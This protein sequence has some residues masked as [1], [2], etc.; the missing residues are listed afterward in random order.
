MLFYLVPK[1]YSYLPEERA[2][3][4]V[5]EYLSNYGGQ[6][7]EVVVSSLLCSLGQCSSL[8]PVDWTG[9]LLNIT[10]GMPNMCKPCLQCAIKLTETS[11]GFHTF[12]AYCCSP[13][14]L[15]GLEVLNLV[16]FNTLLSIS[17]FRLLFSKWLWVNCT[18]WFLI[19]L[20]LH[21]ATC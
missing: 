19:C 8:P 14:V 13:V 21:S 3:P 5:F 9:I 11:K 2:L 20:L 18:F 7:S 12:I 10:R 4:A 16:V 17:H 1:N 15:S 6:Q